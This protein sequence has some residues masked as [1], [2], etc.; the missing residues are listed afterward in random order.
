M[1]HTGVSEMGQDGTSLGFRICRDI[2]LFSVYKLWEYYDMIIREALV[3]LTSDTSG[4]VD[5]VMM[6]N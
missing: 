1:N 3:T 5:L 2:V 4:T 6:K